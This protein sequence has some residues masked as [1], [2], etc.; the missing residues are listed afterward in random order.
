[1]N[2]TPSNATVEDRIL[3]DVRAVHDGAA[4][5]FTLDKFRDAVPRNDWLIVRII[6]APGS[7]AAERLGTAVD[8]RTGRTVD[9][10]TGQE[11]SPEAAPLG[12]VK[13]GRWEMVSA[14]AAP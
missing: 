12:I 4:L 10:K 7:G 11:V 8:I 2:G 5:P 14:L 9:R 1:M 13:M 6:P 3:H